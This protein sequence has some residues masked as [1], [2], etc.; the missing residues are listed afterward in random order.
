VYIATER[1]LVSLDEEGRSVRRDEDAGRGAVG[2]GDYGGTGVQS[3][4]GWGEEDKE[5]EGVESN[6]Q[7]SLIPNDH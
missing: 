5:E 2:P 1:L 7:S 4:G 6:D 3:E